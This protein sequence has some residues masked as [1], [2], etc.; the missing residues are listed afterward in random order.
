[1]GVEGLSSH[2]LNVGEWTGSSPPG[3]PPSGA[4]SCEHRDRRRG[5]VAIQARVELLR[6]S[7]YCVRIAGRRCWP[8]AVGKAAARQRVR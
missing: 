6:L 7:A 4:D 3:H 8:V 5:R 2:L 1:M